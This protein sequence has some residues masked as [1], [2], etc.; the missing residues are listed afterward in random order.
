[1]YTCVVSAS[2]QEIGKA[3]TTVVANGKYSHK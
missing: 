3:N 1:M 2:G